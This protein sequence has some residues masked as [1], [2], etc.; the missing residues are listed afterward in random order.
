MKLKFTILI[1]LFTFRLTPQ[2]L[3]DN[4]RHQLELCNTDSCKTRLEILLLDE[5]YFIDENEGKKLSEKLFLDVKSTD[6]VNYS[7]AQYYYGYYS[8]KSNNLNKAFKIFSELKLNGLKT[9]NKS[10]LA[11]ANFDL[12]FAALP[13]GSG[14]FLKFRFLLYSDKLILRCPF[15]FSV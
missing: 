4:L 13:E 7:N 9:N 11:K 10:Y 15:M 8:L 12:D 1:L 6:T 5:L 14:V 3:I 2:A